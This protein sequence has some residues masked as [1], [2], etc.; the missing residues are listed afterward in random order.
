M[1]APGPIAMGDIVSLATFP[2]GDRPMAFR[3]ERHD[4][5]TG[6]TPGF[7]GIDFHV[8][9]PL[10][11]QDEDGRWRTRLHRH[12]EDPEESGYLPALLRKTC[13]TDCPRKKRDEKGRKFRTC[14]CAR[15][16]RVTL[17]TRS[18]RKTD[19]A[20]S[21]VCGWIKDGMILPRRF[22]P[23][24][25]LRRKGADRVEVHHERAVEQESEFTVIRVKDDARFAGIHPCTPAEHREWHAAEPVAPSAPAPGSVCPVPADTRSPAEKYVDQLIQEGVKRGRPPGRTS[26]RGKR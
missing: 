23:E 18:E 25:W 22:S 24:Q 5:Y 16:L 13:G 11:W 21:R 20:Y 19:E 7:P 8:R 3:H 12:G 1:A 4:Q 2:G 14:D 26:K 10:A 17:V 9:E 6:E 15:Q